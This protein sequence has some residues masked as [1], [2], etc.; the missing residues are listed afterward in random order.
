MKLI[1]I[2]ST[3]VALLMTLAAYLFGS[4]EVSERAGDLSTSLITVAVFVVFMV[5]VS[6]LFSD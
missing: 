6:W 4:E 1:V 3:A 2:G 5:F